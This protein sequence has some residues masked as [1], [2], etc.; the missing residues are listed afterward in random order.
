[1]RRK[2]F[3]HFIVPLVKSYCVDLGGKC[4]V[5]SPKDLRSYRR[6]IRVKGARVVFLCGSGKVISVKNAEK[7]FF[8]GEAVIVGRRFEYGKILD[9]LRYEGKI[10]LPL[11]LMREEFKGRC[12][13]ILLKVNRFIKYPKQ[14]PFSKFIDKVKKPRTKFIP[15]D[16]DLLAQIRIRSGYEH[17]RIVEFLED[18][19]K[20]LGYDTK[21][22]LRDNTAKLDLVWLHRGKPIIAFEVV[23]SSHLNTIRRAINNL[24]HAHSKWGSKLYIIIPMSKDLKGKI[25]RRIREELKHCSEIR[26]EVCICDEKQ[27]I[28]KHLS[29]HN[30]TQFTK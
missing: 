29:S 19:G 14:I 18:L 9:K 11:G 3:R 25:K 24:R 10:L 26:K 6:R 30:I 28:K 1:M 16:E 4:L 21:K 20:S 2:V 22:E 15:I 5:L 13:Y 12:K 27:L 8:V 7:W 23:V 17:K